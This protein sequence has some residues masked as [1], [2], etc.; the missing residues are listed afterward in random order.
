MKTYFTYFSVAMALM[1]LMGLSYGSYLGYQN[2]LAQSWPTVSGKVIESQ[3]TSRQQKRKGSTRTV[4]DFQL[5]YAYEVN[6]RSYEGS[7]LSFHQRNGFAKEEQAKKILTPYPVGT[8]V[9]VHYQPD[10][11][12]VAI[13]DTDP[14]KW[15]HQSIIGGAIVLV[16]SVLTYLLFL[17][18]PKEN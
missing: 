11:P 3:V 14:Q 10:K 1:G 16:L 12:G 9:A 13:L 7:R 6:S 15:V 18:R 2:Y 5:K 8:K 17:R 4:Y